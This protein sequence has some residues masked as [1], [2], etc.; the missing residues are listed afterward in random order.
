VNINQMAAKGK[1]CVNGILVIYNHSLYPVASNMFEHIK[2][3]RENSGFPVWEVNAYF[4]FPEV[5]R[6]LEFKVIVLHYSLFYWLPFYLRDEF[7]EYLCESGNSYKIA[8]FQ[9]EY[10]YSG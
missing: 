10:R 6:E 7:L 3:F 1:T 9:D 8:F 2:A 5:L 4:G